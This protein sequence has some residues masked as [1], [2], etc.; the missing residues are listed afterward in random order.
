MT[1]QVVSRDENTGDVQR[2][3]RNAVGTVGV[4]FMA[5]ATAAPITAM[6]GNVPIAVGFGNGMYAPAG[7][8]VATIV[9]TLFSIGY[10]AMSKHITATGAFYGYISH[11]LGR[12]IGLGA[13]FL[14]A[15]S[16]MV[17]EASLIGIFAFCGNDTFNSLFHV[18]VP[19]IVFAIAMLAINAL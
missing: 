2:L 3:K 8:F 10:A 5:V 19:W 4:I 16:Y 6:V 17:F 1:D 18:N 13:G 11:G 7:Y 12:I 14:T 9:L 15:M